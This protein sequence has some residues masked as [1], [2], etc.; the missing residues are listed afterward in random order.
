MTDFNLPFRFQIQLFAEGGDGG[1]GGEGAA[2]A[3]A[4]ADTGSNAAPDADAEFAAL[5]GK[6]GKFHEQYSKSLQ[7]HMAPR[8]K[9]GSQA[10]QRWEDFGPS[11]IILAR[12][13]GM[14]PDDPGL[15]ARIASDA[16][17]LDGVALK[18][19]RSTDAEMAIAQAEARAAASDNAL[20]GFLIQRDS[21]MWQAQANEMKEA[22]PT[23]DIDACI[24]DQRVQ[25]LL[26]NPAYGG[27]FDF[28]AAMRVVYG[29]QLDAAIAQSAKQKAASAV[30]SGSNRPR[31]NGLGGSG[32]PAKTGMDVA[33]MSSKEFKELMKKVERGERV[34]LG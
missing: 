27:A 33:S 10:Q 17:L 34:V 7:K 22:Y 9:A 20:R 23:I 12:R 4:A 29:D 32:A 26:R 3:A 15:A 6:D 2:N 8:L 31:E 5:I 25:D 21:E 11:R 28:K 19:D 16:S 30:A 14:S 1:A 24:E 18:N 13:Y